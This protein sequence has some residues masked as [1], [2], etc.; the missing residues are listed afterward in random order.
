VPVK[1]IDPPSK[2][3][4]PGEAV[5]EVTLVTSSGATVTVVVAVFVLRGFLKVAVKV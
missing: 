3:T 2:L 1:V 5:K 4:G